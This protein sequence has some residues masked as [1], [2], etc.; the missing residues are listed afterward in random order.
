M[1]RRKCHSLEK[2][3]VEVNLNNFNVVGKDGVGAEVVRRGFP[4]STAGDRGSLLQ[5]QLVTVCTVE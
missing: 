1:E 2:W 3:N 5:L 4:T